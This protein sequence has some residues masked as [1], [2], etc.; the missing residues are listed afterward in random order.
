MRLE[1]FRR[2]NCLFSCSWLDHEQI[3][4]EW[5]SAMGLVNRTRTQCSIKMY[6][7]LFEKFLCFCKIIGS[8]LKIDE[9][10]KTR[11]E[12]SL[13][14]EWNLKWKELEY[15]SL[16]TEFHGN[17]VRR[18]SCWTESRKNSVIPKTVVVMLSHNTKK[19]A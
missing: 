13:K 17:S 3:I 18:N 2:E 7:A 4:P 11:R 14:V 16:I 10:A 12:W 19:V 6:S 15:P 8:S 1:R 5:W 9:V